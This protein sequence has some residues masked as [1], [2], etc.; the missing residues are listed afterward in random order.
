MGLS[1]PIPMQR[2][3]RGINGTRSPRNDVRYVMVGDAFVRVF[4]GGTSIGPSFGIWH[5]TL[6][7]WP[8]SAQDQLVRLPHVVIMA[9]YG[10]P[11][12]LTAAKIVLCPTGL[13][14]P[15]ESSSSFDGVQ[16]LYTGLL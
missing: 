5:R 6:G 16:A 1:S 9:L 14:P 13:G 2:L 15:M 7:A 8:D 3:F 10:V 12:P 11:N 4:E